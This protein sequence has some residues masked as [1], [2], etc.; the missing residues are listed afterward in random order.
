MNLFDFALLTLLN[1][2]V[3]ILLPRFISFNWS[4]LTNNLNPEIGSQEKISD[5]TIAE[6]ITAS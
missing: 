2:T 5:Q 6:N 1:A 3:C 4:S